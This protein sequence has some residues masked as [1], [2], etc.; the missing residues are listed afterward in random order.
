MN[1]QLELLAQYTRMIVRM[2]ADNVPLSRVLMTAQGILMELSVAEELPG[3]TVYELPEDRRARATLNWRD[4]VRTTLQTSS[5]A[6]WLL[7]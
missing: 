7:H 2:P 5:A 4:A 6:A 1:T 3:R